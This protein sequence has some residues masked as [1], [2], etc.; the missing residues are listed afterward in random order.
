MQWISR[1]RALLIMGVVAVGWHYRDQ[2]HAFVSPAV[3]RL[4]AALPAMAPP[5]ARRAPATREVLYTWVDDRGVTHFEQRPGKGKPLVFDGSRITPLEP[6]DPAQAERLRQ[7]AGASPTSAT[8][9]EGGASSSRGGLDSIR[10]DMVTGARAMKQS[11]DAESG[12]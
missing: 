10:S 1:W 7:A 3:A 4:P 2:L 6:V 9:P 5:A 8:A 11:R 12:L